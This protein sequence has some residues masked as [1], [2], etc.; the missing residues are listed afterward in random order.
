[1]CV[2]MWMCKPVSHVPLRLCML[3]D[4]T[5]VHSA[6]KGC[7]L[8]SFLQPLH[9]HLHVSV[10]LFRNHNAPLLIVVPEQH[11]AQ[12]C[13]TL[14]L[15]EGVGKWGAGTGGMH[16]RRQRTSPYAVGVPSSNVRS[17]AFL[18]LMRWRSRCRDRV[19]R[20]ES[21]RSGRRTSHR[22]SWSLTSS[23][24]TR[25]RLFALAWEYDSKND[26]SCEPGERAD[27]RAPARRAGSSARVPGRRT[28]SGVIPAS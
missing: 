21:T 13:H 16:R 27:K 11:L 9:H 7:V 3:G 2:R 4:A 14:R 25:T 8:G 17:R 19:K 22:Y 6:N 20:V 10:P 12:L 15:A 24:T 5:R 26:T 1:M 18:L 23:G 28:C